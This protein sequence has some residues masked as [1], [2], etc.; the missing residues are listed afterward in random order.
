MG[1]SGLGELPRHTIWELPPNNQ[2]I[3]VLEM[4]KILEPYD[5]RR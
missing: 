3:A 5:S 4:L 1:D 2:G